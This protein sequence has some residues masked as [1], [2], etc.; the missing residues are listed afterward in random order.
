MLLPAM[1]ESFGVSHRHVSA[2]RHKCSRGP[3]VGIPVLAFGPAD[4]LGVCVYISVRIT[5]NG[6][7]GEAAS[8]R[9]AKATVA[10]EE[11]S[12]PRVRSMASKTHSSTT[13]PG[14]PSLSA[15]NRN[16]T[17]EHMPL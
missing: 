1:M 16:V 2:G 3:D 14:S 8:R 5:A 9:P 7:G 4:G 15:V 6:E 13:C 10:P 17:D 11:P 12:S